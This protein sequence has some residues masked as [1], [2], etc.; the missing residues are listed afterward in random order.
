MLRY[1]GSRPHLPNYERQG[2]ASSTCFGFGKFL[3]L[4][5]FG[6][7]CTMWHR[8]HSRDKKLPKQKKFGVTL[9]VP[10]RR[11]AGGFWTFGCPSWHRSHLIHCAVSNSLARLWLRRDGRVTGP[12][13]KVSAGLSGPVPS[14]HPSLRVSLRKTR[15]YYRTPPRSQGAFD[16]SFFGLS[17]P[18]CF[19][20]L[21]LTGTQTA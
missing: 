12:G 18:V 1:I 2:T 6:G 15:H 19:H 5:G 3:S 7:V 8:N 17:L 20:R 13:I 21:V 16:F 9:T 4:T 14:L 10:W 11:R